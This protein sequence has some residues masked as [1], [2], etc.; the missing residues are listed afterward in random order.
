MI[1]TVGTSELAAT[2]RMMG[3]SDPHDVRAAFRSLRKVIR[4]V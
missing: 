3:T 2:E 1:G 4:I